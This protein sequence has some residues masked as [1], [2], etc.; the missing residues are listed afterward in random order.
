MLTTGGE[1]M[2]ES[3]TYYQRDGKDYAVFA[4]D[5]DDLW[6]A[7]ERL[8]AGLRAAHLLDDPLYAQVWEAIK[9]LEARGN[10][11]RADRGGRR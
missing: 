2:P 6:W 11:Q 4:W 10:R 8:S 1:G 5:I 3:V 9:H 7:E